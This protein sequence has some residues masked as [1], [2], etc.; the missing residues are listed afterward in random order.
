MYTKSDYSDSALTIGE[1]QTIPKR[2]RW[3]RYNFK[4]S[5][6]AELQTRG[7]RLK[8]LHFKHTGCF[9][10]SIIKCWRLVI[11]LLVVP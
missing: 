6:T 7:V 3:L 9:V 10:Y 2:S 4:I 1:L 8:T 5:K 11:S